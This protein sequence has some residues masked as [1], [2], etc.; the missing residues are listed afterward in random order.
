MHSDEQ[1]EKMILDLVQ[2]LDYDYYKSFLPECSEEP[3]EIPNRMASLVA[4]ARK[5]LDD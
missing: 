2:E 3:E 4:I 5:H 1:L